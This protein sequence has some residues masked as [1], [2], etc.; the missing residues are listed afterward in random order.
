MTCVENASLERVTP[1]VPQ[2][3][4]EDLRFDDVVFIVEADS[5]AEFQL[6]SEF[7]SESQKSRDNGA[8]RWKQDPSGIARQVGVLR[9]M[10]G[11]KLP[12]MC[13]VSF[14]QLNGFR[15]AF[16]TSCSRAVDWDLVHDW[17]EKQCPA[18]A[19]K[20]DAQNFHQCLGKIRELTILS[21]VHDS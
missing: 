21:E 10:K 11:E 6:W 5:F 1:L 7:S 13:S 20:C 18:A 17:M 3:M 4:S 15:V 9:T 16:Y 14:A 2:P 12:V 19:G 8:L